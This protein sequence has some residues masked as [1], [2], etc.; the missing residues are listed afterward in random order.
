MNG[1]SGSHENHTDNQSHQSQL[2][3][4]ARRSKSR[5]WTWQAICAVVGFAGGIVSA[6][7]GVVFTALSWLPVPRDAAAH[8]HSLGTVVFCLTIPLLI[9]GGYCLDLLERKP[10]ALNSLDN[11][12]K[13]VRRNHLSIISI[14]LFLTLLTAMPQSAHAQ[15]TIFNVPST[16]VLKRGSVYAELDA[17]FKPKD[18]EGVKR[19]SSF[20]PRVVVGAGG[21]TEIGL[22]L[23]G[24]VQPGADQTALVPNVKHKFY[25]GGANGLAFVVGDN[26]FVPIRNRQYDVGNYVYL[27]GSK[28]IGN[29]R[30]TAG[31]YHFS[32]NV[33]AANAQRAGGQFGF[34]QTVNS[35]LAFAA[36]WLTGKHAAGYF[37]PGIT[38]KPQ[39]RLTGYAAY[40]L[41]NAGLRQGNHFFLLELGI[42]LK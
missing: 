14:G 25:D 11:S 35:R 5:V 12:D 3:S 7:F 23:T 41:G 4:P 2:T 39:S 6:L 21:R 16:D 38:F 10:R 31:A 36:D 9:F 1:D 8:L 29:T 40:S 24:N 32:R 27:N 42:N 17:S 26:L 18:S 33:V 30:L 28:T 20:V 13:R 22:N 37:T 34:E 15:Q 19:F